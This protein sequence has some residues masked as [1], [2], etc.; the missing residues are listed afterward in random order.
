MNTQR[1]REREA[2]EE[3]TAYGEAMFTAGLRAGRAQVANHI[4]DHP[5]IGA[6]L[7][8]QCGA[9]SEGCAY[10][11]PERAREAAPAWLEELL[12]DAEALWSRGEP[13]PIRAVLASD[14][15]WWKI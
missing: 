1:T 7:D 12:Q 8:S 10:D 9:Q 14:G 11:T 2:I 4:I 3:G 15:W 6:V 13:A 5:E